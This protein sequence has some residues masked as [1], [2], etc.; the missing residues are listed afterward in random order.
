MKRFLAATVAILGVISVSAQRPGA[1][2]VWYG[3]IGPARDNFQIVVKLEDKSGGG[4]FY[5]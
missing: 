2:G 3:A 5:E 1:A 4:A